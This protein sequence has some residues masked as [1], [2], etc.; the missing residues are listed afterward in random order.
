MSA[1]NIKLLNYSQDAI[2]DLRKFESGLLHPC[3]M[4]SYVLRRI[5][6]LISDSTKFILPNCAD[7][8]DTSS[9]TQT[10]L[11]LARLPYSVVV[12]EIPWVKNVPQVPLKN[13]PNKLSTKRIALCIDYTADTTHL[14][15]I[16]NFG[17]LLERYPAGGVLVFSIYKID[18]EDSWLMCQGGSFVPY[19]N[20]VESEKNS[21]ITPLPATV[22]ATEQLLDAGM[23][24]GKN[25]KQFRIEPFIALPELCMH[26]E[27]TLGS[28]DKMFADIL[29]NTRDEVLAYIGACSLLNCANVIIESAGHQ[30]TVEKKLPPSARKKNKPQPKPK[31]EYKVLQISDER[32]S[33]KSNTSENAEQPSIRRT[34]LRRGHIRRLQERLIWVRP[35][36]INPGSKTGV[37][38]KDY[39]VIKG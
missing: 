6:D 26:M 3:P 21:S 36:V 30:P 39:K 7:F 9:F 5:I 35:A 17:A 11:D 12:F 27:H 31:F 22:I 15:P 28:R 18:S 24:S 16:P 37:I 23:I 10:H 8:L 13:F 29:L 32:I 19:D 2:K 25:R 20:K 33:H 14:C 1:E 4:S 38:A 34:H